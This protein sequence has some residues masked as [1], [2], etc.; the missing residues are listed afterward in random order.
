[1]G[2]VKLKPLLISLAIPLGVGMLSRLFTQNAQ[3]YYMALEQPSFSPPSWVFGVVWPILYFLMGLA[4]YRVLVSN[5]DKDAIKRATTV[6]FLQLVL[7]FLYSIVFFR[8]GNNKLA[9]LIT[10]ALVVLNIILFFMYYKIDKAAA[11]LI[12]PYI[13]WLIYAM[14]LM[15][16]IVKLNG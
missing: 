14:I 9:L 7:N 8:L 3:V 1:M 6:Y 5:Y 16:F 12:I 4:S 15:F 11:V 10:I 13:L 2:V